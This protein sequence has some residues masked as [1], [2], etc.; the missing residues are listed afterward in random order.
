MYL[1]SA[2]GRLFCNSF[3]PAGAI[4]SIISRVSLFKLVIKDDLCNDCGACDK[5]CKA[6]CI[7]SG[8]KRIDFSACVGCF[9]CLRSCPTNA[10]VYSHPK[11][12]HSEHSAPWLRPVA[13]KI[14]SR[15]EVLLS[16]RELLR[17][18]G[19]PAAALLLAPG[20]AE[21]TTALMKRHQAISPPGSLSVRR[22]TSICTAC[23][24]CV[25]SCPTNVLRPS[26]LEYGFGGMSQPM[27][28]Y[29]SGSC[30]YD[31]VIC[32]E[33]CPTGAIVK[34]TVPE[35][36]RIQ[37]GKAK[38]TKDDCVVVS[39]KKDCAACSE[40]CPTK[41]VH[42]VPYEGNILI[43]EV[44]DEIC[45]GCGAC[46]HACPTT[47]RKAINVTGNMVHVAAKKPRIEAIPKV[48]Q[49]QPGDFPF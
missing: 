40:H 28:D 1:S 38:F 8:S 25:A 3:C 35:K 32:G 12:V 47:P 9:N 13:A 22:F 46:E 20:I 29:E 27:M 30:N 24:L 17:N 15:G 31:C 14:E 34:Q 10:I 16:R 18:V 6:D 43:P 37:I 26:F 44:D 48:N 41:A 45:I 5:V 19:I 2:K 42:T 21:S 7:D 4:L 36:K 33:V 49:S 39:K 23:H 11:R